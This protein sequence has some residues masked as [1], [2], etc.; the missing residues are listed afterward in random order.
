MECID[1]AEGKCVVRH[2]HRQEVHGQH[3]RVRGLPDQHGALLRRPGRGRARERRHVL[4]VAERCVPRLAPPRSPGDP[5]GHPKPR[6]A[7]ERRG[8]SF[9]R[10]APGTARTTQ[11][12]RSAPAST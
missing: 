2:Q 10:E 3:A 12:P 4:R 6:G 7:R 11:H 1:K 8:A 5:G 9:F